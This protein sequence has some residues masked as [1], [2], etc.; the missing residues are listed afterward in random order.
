MSANHAR[1]GPSALKSRLT[2]SFAESLF[3]A[4]LSPDG[5]LA[6]PLVTPF[7]PYSPI[8]RATRF[9]EVET[10]FRLSIMNTLAAPYTPRLFSY[11]SPMSL[12]SSRSRSSCALGGLETWA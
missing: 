11:S 1:L 10:P 5:R 4:R 9:F 12:A 6:L 3:D 2:R 7:H 8:I